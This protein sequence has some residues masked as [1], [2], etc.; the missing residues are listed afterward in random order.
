MQPALWAMAGAF[1]FATMVKPAASI[2]FWLAIVVLLLF[3][4][5]PVRTLLPV[6]AAYMAAMLVWTWCYWAYSPARVAPLEA[7]LE[8][9]K[10]D[11]QGFVSFLVE[12]PLTPFFGPPNSYVGLM[13][14][15]KFYRYREYPPESGTRA[16][17]VGIDRPGLMDPQRPAI[18]SANASLR[19]FAQHWPR[20]MT[21]SQDC[22]DEFG[23]DATRVLA[24]MLDGAPSQRCSPY[25]LEWLWTW[26]TLMH[27]EERAGSMLMRAAF[28]TAWYEPIARRILAADWLESAITGEGPLQPGWQF[29][30]IRRMAEAEVTGAVE[31]GKANS[32]PAAMKPFLGELGDRPAWAQNVAGALELQDFER[33][34]L[35]PLLFAIT[36]AG[37]FVLLLRRD[38]AAPFASFLVL[39]YLGS[40][41]IWVLVMIMPTSDARHEA[42]FSVLPI[43]GAPLVLARLWRQVC[44]R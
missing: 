3:R 21:L 42:V 30:G 9:G 13:F 2:F 12:R 34:R 39:A 28:E 24:W 35:K 23:G 4:I 37:C 31:S 7:P 22:L 5:T 26:L 25:A 18:A 38:R 11:P 15:M 29:V 43:L 27:G 36:A 41:T 14:F 44:A 20:F 33:W 17:L 8:G 10:R 19:K 32:L 1:C 16:W 6:A 40:A